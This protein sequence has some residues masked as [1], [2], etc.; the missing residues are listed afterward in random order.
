MSLEMGIQSEIDMRGGVRRGI[1]FGLHTFL[2]IPNISMKKA[3]AS[4]KIS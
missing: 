3:I 1:I 2:D 4:Y